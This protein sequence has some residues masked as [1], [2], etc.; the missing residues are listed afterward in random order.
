MRFARQLG[1][2]PSLSIEMARHLS[3][4][5]ELFLL[6]VVPGEKS[7]QSHMLLPFLDECPRA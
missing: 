3:L 1:G 2:G 7:S 4:I 6:G 5:S